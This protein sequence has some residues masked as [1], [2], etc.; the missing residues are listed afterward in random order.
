MA[1]V[2]VTSIKEIRR[3]VDVVRAQFSDLKHHIAHNVHRNFEFT[4]H[5]SDERSCDFTQRYRLLGVMRRDE[6][7]LERKADGSLHAKFVGGPSRGTETFTS[8]ESLGSGSTRVQFKVVMPLRG[9]MALAR[10]FVKRQVERDLAKGLEE[11]RIDL[12]ER[13]YPR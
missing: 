10:P 3:P 12:E 6:V 2:T 5:A 11:D 7:R 13:G 1:S 4:L 8:F 9:L